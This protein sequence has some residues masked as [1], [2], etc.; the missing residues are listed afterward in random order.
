MFEEIVDLDEDAD[1]AEVLHF[2]QD[3]IRAVGIAQS[4]C[5]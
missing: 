1:L 2:F 3:R 4:Q 5:Q